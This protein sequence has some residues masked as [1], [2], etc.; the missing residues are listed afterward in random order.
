MNQKKKT[1]A[2]IEQ[3][4]LFMADRPVSMAL[5]VITQHSYLEQQRRI[6]LALGPAK[7]VEHS[8]YH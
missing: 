2:Y 3:M 7:H 4:M 1:L 5:S 6:Y 8:I